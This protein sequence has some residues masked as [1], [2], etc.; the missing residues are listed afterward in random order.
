MTQMPPVYPSGEW[1]YLQGMQPVGPVPLAN[2]MAM[3]QSGLIGPHSLVWR[4][5]LAQ[6]VPAGSLP[7]LAACFLARTPQYLGLTLGGLI[8]FIILIFSCLPL[9][10]LPWVIPA[11]RAPR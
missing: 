9:C 11:L 5:G 3:V 4:T 8:V 7:E 2:I 6:W 10:W 1:Y